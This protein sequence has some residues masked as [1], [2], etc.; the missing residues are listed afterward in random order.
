MARKLNKTYGGLPGVKAAL[1]R[2]QADAREIA[3]QTG[4]PLVVFKDGQIQMLP[5]KSRKKTK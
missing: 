4:T 5:M 3:R 1:E 2:A